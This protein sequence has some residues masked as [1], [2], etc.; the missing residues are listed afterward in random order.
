MDFK[1]DDYHSIMRLYS[2]QNWLLKKE[3]ALKELVLFCERKDSKNL[4]FSL[5]ERFHYLQEDYLRYLLNELSH[6]IIYESGFKPETIQI[7]SFTC[8][9][10]A[11]SSQKLLDMI[12]V[13]LFQGGWRNPSIVNNFNLCETHFKKGKTQVLMMD[14][15]IGSGKTLHNRF[16]QLKDI[17]KGDF[18][19]KFCFIAGIRK[20]I[21]SIQAE[22][23]Y[24][25][26]PLQLDKGISDFYKDDTLSK[27]IAEMVY[28]ESKLSPKINTKDLSTY[29]FGYGNAEALYSLEGCNGNTPNSTFPLFWWLK[30]KQENDRITI[31]TRVEEG[32]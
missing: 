27:M 7:L 13:P 11:D 4:V 10:T 18:E 17:L 1:K 2:K 6:Y 29:S 15:F 26:C 31:L 16:R 8:D 21:E 30:D 19:I 9:E 3:K 14:E 32:F 22:G 12:K 5:L 28:L 23:I 24:V 25:F 20:T